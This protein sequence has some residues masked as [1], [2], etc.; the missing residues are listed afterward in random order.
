MKTLPKYALAVMALVLVVA[1]AT[2]AATAFA[3]ER[4]NHLYRSEAI[5]RMVNQGSLSMLQAKLRVMRTSHQIRAVRVA[6]AAPR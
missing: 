4:K 3:G 2:T 5:A 1:T 6:L